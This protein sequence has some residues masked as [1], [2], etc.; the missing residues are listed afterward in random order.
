M[1]LIIFGTVWALLSIIGLFLL[2]AVPHSAPG[3]SN[4]DLLKLVGICGVLAFAA[5]LLGNGVV[6]LI[7]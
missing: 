7:T 4:S 6:A 2:A 5:C 1:F 3:A